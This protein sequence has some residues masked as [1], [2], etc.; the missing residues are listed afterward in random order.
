[1]VKLTENQK[2]VIFKHCNHPELVIYYIEKRIKHIN[3]KTPLTEM[4]DWAELM[5]E[6]Q[7]FYPD[8]EKEE[9]NGDE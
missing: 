6:E 2:E 1:M 9:N 7:R 8:D 5:M 4:I 3:E